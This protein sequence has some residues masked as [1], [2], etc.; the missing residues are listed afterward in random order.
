M[1]LLLIRHGQ[2]ECNISNRFQDGTDRLTA[3]GLAQARATAAALAAETEMDIIA[4]YASPLDRAATTARIIGEAIGQ[5]PVVLPELAETDV[6]AAANLTIAEFQAR[7][8]MIPLGAMLDA[9]GL[10]I[11]WPEGETGREMRDRA[12]D[13]YRSIV[14]RH[15]REPGTVLIVSHGGPLAWITALVRGESLERWP[16]QHD[17]MGNCSISEVLIPADLAMPAAFTRW[18]DRAHLA[19]IMPGV[20]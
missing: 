9:G 20:S 4:L 13:A 17:S 8:P 19:A 10:D 2:T 11:Q 15:R 12:L 1:R 18:D 16:T 3:L 6:G 14:Q 7:F 5:T